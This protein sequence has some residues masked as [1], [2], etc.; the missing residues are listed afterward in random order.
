M[1]LAAESS[2]EPTPMDAAAL[3]VGGVITFH[4]ETLVVGADE[5]VAAIESTSADAGEGR[6]RFLLPDVPV[7]S[8]GDAWIIPLSWEPPAA[9]EE[10][11]SRATQLWSDM[12]G[13]C[14]YRH[15]VQIGID[16]A[17]GRE[18]ADSYAAELA[19]TG[20]RRA[21]W[22]AF[23]DRA[24]VLVIYGDPAPEPKTSIAVHVV[25]RNWVWDDA[26]RAKVTESDLVTGD[27]S[28]SW[29]DVVAAADAAEPRAAGSLAEQKKEG[30]ES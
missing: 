3:R 10:T 30:Q 27:L 11:R 18:S 14:E 15:G 21:D 13:A 26:A 17:S 7:L 8:R 2:D 25:P 5:I 4:G 29:A 24:I 20:A 23:D 22:W 19:R 1:S 12:R 16:L 9:D 28:W 6:D